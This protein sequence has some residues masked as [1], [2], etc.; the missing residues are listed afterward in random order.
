MADTWN[1]ATTK[2]I[3][4]PNFTLA[5]YEHIKNEYLHLQDSTQKGML[6]AVTMITPIPKQLLIIRMRHAVTILVYL[7]VRW[8]SLLNQARVTLD[9]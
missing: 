9:E 5:D 1:K 4:W 8:Q 7:F 2:S 6:N 3:F